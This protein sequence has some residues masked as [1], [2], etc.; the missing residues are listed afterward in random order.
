MLTRQTISVLIIFALIFVVDAN[1][2][3]YKWKDENGKIHFTDDP[4]SVP[5][6]FR[7][8]PFIKGSTVAPQITKPIEKKVR[9][10]GGAIPKEKD[11]AENGTKEEVKQ[12][13]LTEAQRSAAE[14]AVQFFKED[15][16]RYDKHYLYP[17]SRSK[18]RA[19]KAAVAVATPKKQ[20]LLDIISKL[21]L[22]LFESISGFLKTSIAADEKSQKVMPTTLP[23]ARQT[24]TLMNRLKSETRQEK[25]FLEE[26]TA[27]L[28]AKK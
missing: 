6:A 24:N 18:F 22:P 3:I 20:A 19:I 5:E 26:L 28:E 21:D 12:E 14:S 13:G 16:P 8:K 9:D 10:E 23:S 4:T 15:I 11:S 17:P 2:A 7:K 1:A 25:K 27:E